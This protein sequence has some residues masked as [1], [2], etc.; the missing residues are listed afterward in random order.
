MQRPFIVALMLVGVASCAPPPPAAP[1]GPPDTMSE[2]VRGM[3]SSDVALIGEGANHGD[4]RTL[5]FKSAL[6]QRLVE[7]CGFDAIVFESGSYDFLEIDRRQLMGETVTRAMV[8]SAVGGLWNRDDEVQPLITWMHEALTA[9]RIRIG[10]LDDQLGSAGAFYSISEM[11]AE[12][13]GVL[14]PE[15]AAVCRRAFQQLIYGQV[16][17]SPAEKAPVLACLSEIGS[18][19]E[20][21]PESDDR[22][23]RLQ[24]LANAG[25]FASRQGADTANY[26]QGRSQSMWLNYQWWVSRRFPPGTK[27][28]VWGATVHLSRD[29][30]AYPSFAGV[31]NFGSHIDETYGDRAFFLGFSAGGGTYL[32]GNQLRERVTG[33]G[34]LEA[35]ALSTS[36]EDWVYL[37]QSDLER[38][39]PLPALVFHPAPAPVAAPWSDILDGLVVFREEQAPSRKLPT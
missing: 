23:V 4:G 38:S 14:D 36:N 29:A 8:S 10:G 3:C 12:L 27:V 39:G 24:N 37:D 30:G 33:P 6:V 13:S 22:Q 25:R 21:M 17:P 34:S 19:V 7:Q 9:R 15:R 18:A 26:I 1:G 31:R 5:A 32:N 20:A 28:I 11:P 16:G 35:A 2:V